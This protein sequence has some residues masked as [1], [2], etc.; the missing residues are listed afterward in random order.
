MRDTRDRRYPWN[1]RDIKV[2]ANATRVRSSADIANVT[3]APPVRPP[4][5]HGGWS[6]DAVTGPL[7]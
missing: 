2:Q 7:E 5:F 6:S 3:D 4:G 1:T